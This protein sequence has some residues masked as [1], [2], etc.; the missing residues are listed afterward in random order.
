MVLKRQPDVAVFL[1]WPSAV[2]EVHIF[3]FF[4]LVFILL[5]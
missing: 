5:F 4:I 1:Q 3:L 2:S